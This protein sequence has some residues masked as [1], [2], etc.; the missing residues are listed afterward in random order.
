MSLSLWVLMRVK[1]SCVLE[2]LHCR[3]E[4]KLLVFFHHCKV[5]FILHL[6]WYFSVF[7]TVRGS[8]ECLWELEQVRNYRPLISLWK[9]G[10]KSLKTEKSYKKKHLPFPCW[11]SGG[12]YDSDFPCVAT[13][14]DMG[15]GGNPSGAGPPTAAAPSTAAGWT[16]PLLQRGYRSKIIR[17]ERNQCDYLPSCKATDV[18]LFAQSAS[19]MNRYLT[20]ML[21]RWRALQNAVSD[22]ESKLPRAQ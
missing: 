12:F 15:S 21:N 6:F 1:C 14:S 11:S 5:N 2:Q 9:T 4:P 22:T 16:L 13:R 7:Q 3:W 10:L 17:I 8:A 19:V 20:D 18:A